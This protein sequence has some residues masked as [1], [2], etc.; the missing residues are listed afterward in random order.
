MYAWTAGSHRVSHK[1]SIPTTPVLPRFRRRWA[2]KRGVGNLCSYLVIA[3]TRIAVF[4]ELARLEVF[5][6]HVQ[7][8]KCCSSRWHKASTPKSSFNLT[9]AKWTAIESER[10]SSGDNTLS[11]FFLQNHYLRVNVDGLHESKSG[12]FMPNRHLQ[13]CFFICWSNKNLFSNQNIRNP[14]LL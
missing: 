9:T 8:S 12:H 10:S 3:S 1:T 13:Q 11:Q 4:N 2:K 6:R 7:K 5:F 14:C